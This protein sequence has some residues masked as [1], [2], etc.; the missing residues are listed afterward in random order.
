M[1]CR[2]C[3]FVCVK[4]DLFFFVSLFVCIQSYI[5]LSQE[6]A[7][8]AASAVSSKAAIETRISE[9]D[10]LLNEA[11]GADNAYFALKGECY[12]LN[13][14][15][16]RYELCPFSGVTQRGADGSGGTNMGTWQKTTGWV[17]GANDKEW[18]FSDGLGCWNGPQ[19]STRVFLSCGAE[20]VLSDVKEP[21]KV[22]NKHF[23]VCSL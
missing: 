21:N 6:A 10:A 9:L 20:N 23:V 18:K 12:Q 7:N 11:F 22:S 1:C 17:A 4:A 8:V 5:K 15:E 19:R 14:N 2:R 16:Y 3:V 13:T